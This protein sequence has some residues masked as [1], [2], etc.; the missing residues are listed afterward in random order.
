MN[1]NDRQ[2]TCRVSRRQFVS[3]TSSCLAAASLGCEAIAQSQTDRSETG[4]DEQ[5]RRWLEESKQAVKSIESIIV[6]LS[7]DVW[8]RPA[9]G[10]REQE[11]MELHIRVLEKAG[12]LDRERGIRLSPSE[13][14][15]SI[16]LAYASGWDIESLRSQEAK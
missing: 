8:A 4:S 12:F 9:I 6:K 13:V 3:T 15:S 10:L 11:A 1:P 2:E 14:N 16:S 5:R 7:R